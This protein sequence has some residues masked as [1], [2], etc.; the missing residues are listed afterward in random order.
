M[1]TGQIRNDI[2]KLWEKFWTGGITNPLTVIE[3]ISYLM[4]SRMLDMQE[5]MAERKANRTGKDFSRLFPNTPEGQ[6]LRWKNFKQKSGKELQT[7]LKQQVFPFFAT[8]GKKSDQQDGLGEEGSAIEALGHIGEYMQDADLEIKNE[9]VLVNAINIVDRLPLTQS[10]VKGDIYEYLLSKLTTAGINGQFRTPRHIIDA[11]IELMDPQPTDVI[12]DPSCG[13]AGFLART[14]EYLNRVHSS[15][16]GIF[17]DEDGNKHYTGDKLEPFRD[18]INKQMFWGFDFDTTMLRVSSMNMALHGVNG[19]NILYQDSLSKSI[20]EHYPRQEE[21]FFDVILA[22][23]PF[24]GSLDETNTNPD[25]LGLV[26]TK[27]TELLFVAHIL[28]SLKLGG[29]AAVIV[30]DGVLFGS[31]KAHQQLRQ[32]LLENNQLE[33][34]I[35]LPSGVFKPYAG[36]STAILLF[37][38]GGTTER[39]WFYDLQA[40]GYSLDDKR[41]ELKGEGSNDLPDA[42]AKW[43]QYRK[44]V[45]TNAPEADI[46]QAFGDKKQK[47]FVVDAKDIV[48]QK[49]D[50][51]INRYKEVVYA[52]Q[53]YEDPKLI[54]K[55]LKALESEIM[56]DLDEL[57][58]ML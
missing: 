9:S 57:E 33:G 12:C 28:R 4:F 50:L 46:Q 43:K 6:L 40:D 41:N 48:A 11:M 36:V 16:A 45:E 20:K 58:A 30:P 21:N 19:A 31:S 15:E 13:T 24:K 56:A 29:R 32:E 26:K 17:T 37:T 34:I 44:L 35:S 47:A 25:V 52:E 38:K 7:H 51:S 1:L 14:M 42:I 10:D 2:D 54:L 5:D 18:H 3:Q 27:K 53:Q 49:F 55:K 23:P 39:V 22:N 8:L